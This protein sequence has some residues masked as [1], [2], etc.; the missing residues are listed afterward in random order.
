MVGSA[1]LVARMK[2]R[3]VI[4]RFVVGIPED[5]RPIGR[6]G[7]RWEDIIKMDF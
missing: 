5:K 2:K 7:H 1:G 4:Y 3:R 6:P